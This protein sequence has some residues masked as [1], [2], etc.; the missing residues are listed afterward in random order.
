MSTKRTETIDYKIK[1]VWRAIDKMYNKEAAKNDATT[2]TAMVLL[3]IDSQD[4]TPATKIGP[5]IGVEPRSLSRVFEALESKKIIT[6]KVDKDDARKVIVH[7]TPLG[8]KKKEHAKEVV[9]RFNNKLVEKLGEKKMNKLSELLDEVY[10]IS[11]NS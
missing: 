1:Q 2:T 4:G 3:N 7:L 5:L 9:K 8:K 10:Q 6:R 11:I